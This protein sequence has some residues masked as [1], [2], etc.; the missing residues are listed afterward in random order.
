MIRSRGWFGR[1]LVKVFVASTER[2]GIHL[3]NQTET[4]TLEQVSKKMHILFLLDVR[5]LM[6]WWKL[7]VS[8]DRFDYA[9]R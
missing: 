8:A 5:W 7:W 2:D 6:E 4:H 1:V 9:E 3:R